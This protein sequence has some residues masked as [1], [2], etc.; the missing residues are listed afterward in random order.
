[1][2][3]FEL[4]PPTGIKPVADSLPQ[5]DES[6]P[7]RVVAV[8]DVKLPSPPGIEKELDH[9]YVDLWEFQRD[10]N[11]PGIVYRAENVRLIFE[12]WEQQ[13]TER[14]ALR[15]LGIEI[16]SVSEGERKLISAEIGYIR[17]RGLTPGQETLL[18]LD[19][20]GNWLELFESR[21]IM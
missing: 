20:A 10:Q 11:L 2:E 4:E 12:E 17:Q 7:V 15:R 5:M 14:P 1:M 9:F 21:Q 6:L 16:R 19:P 3:P 13:P 8:A 18:V